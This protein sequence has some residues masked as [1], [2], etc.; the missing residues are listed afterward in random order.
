MVNI[1]YFDCFAGVCAKRLLGALL[2][3]GLDKQVADNAL[4]QLNPGFTYELC[5][6]KTQIN[7]I[8]CTAASVKTDHPALQKDQALALLS[9]ASFSPPAVSRAV[10]VIEK[11]NAVPSDVFLEIVACCALIGA[12]FS[13]KCMSAPLRDGMG[14]KDGVPLPLPEVLALLKTY[15]VPY[16][17]L[18][19]AEPFCTPDGVALIAA[20]THEYGPIPEMEIAKIGYGGADGRL[21]RV[22]TGHTT[23]DTLSD[24]FETSMELDR[25]EFQNVSYI[26]KEVLA[27]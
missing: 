26:S 12:L 24:F 10:S 2:D 15:R 18:E 27:R 5:A 6:N 22:I 7:A 13:D 4:L 25:M 3:L 11:L 23:P 9:R 20:H 21:L 19:S 17:I 8:D 1:L 14:V 16:R